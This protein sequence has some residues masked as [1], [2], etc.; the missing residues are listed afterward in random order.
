[1]RN[2]WFREYCISS[3]MVQKLENYLKENEFWEVDSKQTKLLTLSNEPARRL[4][5]SQTSAT[6]LIF[7]KATNKLHLLK[8][9]HYFRV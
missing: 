4:D 9:N 8:K 5:F 2:K 1:M 3:E 6:E 7:S